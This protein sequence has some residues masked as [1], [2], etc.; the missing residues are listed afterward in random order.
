M[1]ETI[2]HPK[3]FTVEGEEWSDNEAF[4]RHPDIATL[5][6]WATVLEAEESVYAQISGSLYNHEL[7]RTTGKLCLCCLGV[8]AHEMGAR[9]RNEFPGIGMTPDYIWNNVAIPYG[10]GWQPMS[11]SYLPNQFATK[12]GFKSTLSA[13]LPPGL[14]KHIF[15]PDT[16]VNEVMAIDSDAKTVGEHRNFRSLTWCTQVSAFTLQYAVDFSELN[17]TVLL[18]F[19]QIAMVVRRLIAAWQDYD[20]QNPET[21]FYGFIYPHGTELT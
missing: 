1:T 8:L 7:T 10:S 13:P 2:T 21:E 3:G 18:S 14:T 20:T 19:R 15:A 9:F 17:D 16:W 4:T 11:L 12:I 6:A 5:D